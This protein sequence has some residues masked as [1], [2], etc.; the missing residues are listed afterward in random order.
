MCI[1]DSVTLVGCRVALL[2]SDL[3][4]AMDPPSTTTYSERAH[5]PPWISCAECS[6]AHQNEED[7][8]NHLDPKHNLDAPS[9]NPLDLQCCGRTVT[10]SPEL[11]RLGKATVSLIH[12]AGQHAREVGH[13]A[14]GTGDVLWALFNAEDASDSAA[15]KF[16]EKRGISR[17]QVYSSFRY[18]DNVQYI[19][20][21]ANRRSAAKGAAVVGSEDLL[22]AM[23]EAKE[24][25]SRS[26]AIQF[27]QRKGITEAQVTNVDAF[28]SSYTY[29]AQRVL[30][31]AQ[32]TAQS[33]GKKWI[34]TEDLLH[35]MFEAD[36]YGK[37]K[38]IAFLERRGV[39]PT[40]FAGK[41]EYSPNVQI[42]LAAAVEHADKQGHKT[43]GTEDVLYALFAHP[44]QTSGARRWL[45][46]RGMTVE[47][48]L[49]HQPQQ[50]EDESVARMLTVG[51]AAG[52]VETLITQ[53]L[54]YVKN[55][56]QY[57]QPISY[58]PAVMYRGV[59]I[60][61][62]SIGPISAV[63][64][65]A[66]GAFVQA[67]QKFQATDSLSAGVKVG[68]AALSGMVSTFLVSPCELVMISQQRLGGTMLGEARNIWGA[69]GMAGLLRGFTPTLVRET[70]WTTCFLGLAP[71]LKDVLQDDSRFFCAN[72]VAASAAAS[73]VAGQVAAVV[74]QPA[75]TIKT[76]MQADRGISGP[77]TY[78]STLGAS[79][80]LFQEGGMGIFFKGLFAR[81][82]RCQAA[83]FILG[84]AGTR[85]SS[86]CDRYGVLMN[87]DRE[88]E[89]EKAGLLD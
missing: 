84:E 75:D 86:F 85:M 56:L 4:Q 49:C 43:V 39:S 35:A 26:Q 57:K 31:S 30:Q 50:D 78:K 9:T 74:T 42:A 36:E 7:C 46:T 65:A 77:M 55:T 62:G 27:L 28:T 32:A 2:F 52:V 5:A 89:E 23:F 67:Y 63:Q 24:G 71:V 48:F 19:L 25:K 79:K 41:A 54:V 47:P 72:D 68:L 70:G 1:R 61:A 13:R 82:L 6:P 33:A 51:G 58:S 10:I 44:Y 37:S 15:M 29:N 20:V 64:W 8:L 88:E 38:G 40:V 3:T 21:A 14:I 59:A 34:G 22:H 81:S 66:N 16:M 45:V 18:S 60:N 11:P 53:P 17:E 76:R 69:H 87:Q 12:V 73:M 80:L 83:V